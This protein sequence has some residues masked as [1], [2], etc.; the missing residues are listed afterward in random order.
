MS[1]QRE[2]DDSRRAA[3]GHERSMK[4]PDDQAPRS[5]TGR[6]SKQKSEDLTVR[7]L[8]VATSMFADQGYTATSMEKIAAACNAGK[9]T[10]YRR[11]PSKEA[12]FRGVIE[13]IRS[14][15]LSSL[16]MNVP[17]S[18]APFE[19]LKAAAHWFLT[20]HLEPL[21]IAMKRITLSEAAV[22]KQSLADGASGDPTVQCLIELV[23]AAQRSGDVADGDAAFI[24]D[25]LIY[26]LTVKPITYAML[27][28][29]IFGSGVAREE[30]FEQAWK[31]FMGGAGRAA[32]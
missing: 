32:I 5:K 2:M 29:N 13:R 20:A 24:A 31:L 6:P 14:R 1:Q 27:G 9:D 11:F 25:Q 28:S 19:R 18:G 4:H 12:L 7:I 30:Y 21:Q 26:S 10:V 17:T 22:F 8:D 16:Q 3:G 15:A 23:A